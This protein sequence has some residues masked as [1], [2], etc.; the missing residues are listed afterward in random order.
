MT[1]SPTSRLYLPPAGEINPGDLYLAVPS[2]QIESRPLLVA[3]YWKE[4]SRGGSIYGVYDADG[5]PPT[6]GFRWQTNQGGETII[7]R[8][9]MGPGMI[10]SHECE[11]DTDPDHRIVAMVRP[12]TDIQVSHRNAILEM[13][14]WAAFPLEAQDEEPPMA[15]SFVDFRRLT[16]VRAAALND[17]DRVAS[18]NPDLRKAL[19]VRFWHYLNRR[20]EPPPA[21]ELPQ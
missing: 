6:G 11:I 4:S 2:I 7:V 1:S 5:T 16:T 20:V 14:N 3:R 21:V 13:R 19:R 8:A 12:I 17:E 9:F 18:L 15:L 10:L